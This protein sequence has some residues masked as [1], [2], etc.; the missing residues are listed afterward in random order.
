MAENVTAN[1]VIDVRPIYNGEKDEIIFS[2]VIPEEECGLDDITFDSPLV[3]SGRV[4]RRAAGRAGSEDYVELELN[5]SA[6]IT[7]QCARCLEDVKERLEF[8]R[9]YGLTKTEVSE[10]SEEYISVKGGELDVSE[11]AR[12]MFLLNVPMR[13]LCSDDC[14]GLCFG[15]GKNLNY[16]KCDCTEE[17]EIDPRMAAL[18]KFKSSEE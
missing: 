15:C 17:K 3:A 6:D 7:A 16:G 1:G 13:F 9:V 10:D 5:V 14:K 8:S 18:L 12:A 11:T 2:F 4:S